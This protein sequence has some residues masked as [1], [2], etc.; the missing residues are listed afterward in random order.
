MESYRDQEYEIRRMKQ[1]IANTKQQAKS[2]ELSTTPNQPNVRRYAKKVAAKG[3]S[4][5]K[6]LERYLSS[7]D[8]VEK[9]KQ[10][11]QMKL[12]FD[13]SPHLG[14]QVLEIDKLSFGYS[15]HKP[16]LQDLDL[17]IQAG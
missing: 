13:K 9:P 5:E 6:K 11:W 12:E 2:V 1:D 17:T 3:K 4:R 8:R 15:G 14:R 10:G 7:S 16:L